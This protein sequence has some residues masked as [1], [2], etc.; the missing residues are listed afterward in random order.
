[1]PLSEHEERILAEIERNLKAEDPKF[2]QRARRVVGV[3]TPVRRLRWAVAG[4]LIGLV[5]LLALTFHI[6]FGFVGFA[7][8]LISVV[9]GVEALR[10]SVDGRGADLLGRIRRAFGRSDDDATL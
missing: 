3:S 1:M 9:V 10:S 6:A 7:L 2:V 5:S 8:M 4:F